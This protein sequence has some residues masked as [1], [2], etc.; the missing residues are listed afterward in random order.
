MR[1]VVILSQVICPQNLWL[2]A[3]KHH[4]KHKANIEYLSSSQSNPRFWA[5]RTRTP[6]WVPGLS[7][8]LPSLHWQ[9]ESFEFKAWR[10]VKWPLAP[11]KVAFSDKAVVI[12]F[13]PFSMLT[14][15]AHVTP[16]LRLQSL[17]ISTA[18]WTSRTSERR[19]LPLWWLLA[20][21]YLTICASTSENPIT[22]IPAV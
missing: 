13:L 17:N 19:C 2:Q 22:S 21:V 11:I 15:K 14:A 12:R 10:D 16:D 6:V 5:T 4:R 3:S 8:A 7:L 9:L 20:Y 1:G 18:F